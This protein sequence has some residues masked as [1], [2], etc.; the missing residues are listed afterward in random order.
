MLPDKAR[1][2]PDALD[3]LSGHLPCA[4]TS[5]SIGG[6]GAVAEFHHTGASMTSRLTSRSRL[7]AIRVSR[8]REVKLIAYEMLSGIPESWHHGVL[9]C[10]PKARAFEPG[11]ALS[12]LGVD[13][14]ALQEDHRCGILFDL[15]AGSA[16]FRF[17]VRLFEPAQ[18]A[19]ARRFLGKRVVDGH[20]DLFQRLLLWS[21]HRVVI[22][23]IARIEVY[24]AIASRDGK[25]PLGPHTHLI[26]H[27]LRPALARSSYMPVPRDYVIGLTAYPAHP[28]RDE[29]GR[30]KPFDAG[31]HRSFQRLLSG[32]GDPE[33]LAAKARA[34]RA[35]M[36]G[37]GSGRKPPEGSRLQR[38][39]WRIAARQLPYELA[40]GLSEPYGRAD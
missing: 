40:E 22:S 2:P 13:A 20:C 31:Q 28:V 16:A 8:A 27:L 26:P 23:P 29:H 5:W 19:F 36:Q 14:D 17:C 25:T 18:I 10:V 24:Q 11:S 9:V 33:Y 34:R 4:S 7:G 1:E 21:P 12:E 15:G 37:S 30:V 6:F 3:I 38:N 35:L 39:A 32:Y